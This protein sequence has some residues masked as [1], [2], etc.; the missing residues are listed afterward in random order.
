MTYFSRMTSDRTSAGAA[1]TAATAATA[2]RGVS[3]VQ[4]PCAAQHTGSVPLHLSQGIIIAKRTSLHLP[5]YLYA[6]SKYTAPLQNIDPD[7]A[8]SSTCNFLLQLG[9]NT[10]RTQPGITEPQRF[11]PTQRSAEYYR[12]LKCVNCTELRRRTI[13]PGK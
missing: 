10:L 12:L 11:R 8:Q 3:L 2:A 7:E 13:S 9:V 4:V 5:S 1:A 6:L